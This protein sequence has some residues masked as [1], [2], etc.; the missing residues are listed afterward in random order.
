MTTLFISDLSCNYTV[1]YTCHLYQVDSNSS[2]S[3]WIFPFGD[4]SAF[5]FPAGLTL[6]YSSIAHCPPTHCFS[7]VTTDDKGGHLYVSCLL[8]YAP[9]NSEDVIKALNQ[10]GVDDMVSFL[11]VLC[12]IHLFTYL[13]ITD[14]P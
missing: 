7:F 4:L 10:I 11:Y 3:S 14:Y 13:C 9:I 2:S 5:I 1:A 12:F 6:K 8:F